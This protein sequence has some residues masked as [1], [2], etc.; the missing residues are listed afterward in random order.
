M[1]I[2]RNRNRGLSK[3]ALEALKDYEPHLSAKS[4]RECIERTRGE[5]DL[6]EG[7]IAPIASNS[8]Y[9]VVVELIDKTT[10]LSISDTHMLDVTR[11]KSKE[12]KVENDTRLTFEVYIDCC[13]AAILIADYNHGEMSILDILTNSSPCSVSK[14]MVTLSLKAG[15]VLIDGGTL[16]MAPPP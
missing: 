14:G 16:G 15:L 13:N 1:P 2:R 11:I 10:K 4:R 3:A 7:I 8:V 9:A 6:E 5:G 12:Y